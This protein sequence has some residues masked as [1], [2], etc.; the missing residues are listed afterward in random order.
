MVMMTREDDTALALARLTSRG[1]QIR[2][3]GGGGS[4]AWISPMDVA[5]CCA[6]LSEPHGAL[7][8][9]KYCNDQSAAIKAIGGICDLL[10]A[11]GCGKSTRLLAVIVLELH[12]TGPICSRCKG[13]GTKTRKDGLVVNC[14]RCEGAGRLSAPSTEIARRAKI[15]IAEYRKHCAKAVKAVQA[16]LEAGESAAIMHVFRRMRME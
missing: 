1:V 2:G 10:T 13:R 14:E 12:I 15:D 8:L 9:A 4:R 16:R 6:G 11:E 7:L 5:A 3:D